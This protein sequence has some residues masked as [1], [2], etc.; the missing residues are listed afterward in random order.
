MAQNKLHI[1]IGFFVASLIGVTLTFSTLHSHHN[2][3]LHNSSEFSDTGQCLTDS[4]ILCPIC[5]HLVQSKEITTD[6]SAVSF[7]VINKIVEH[8][9]NKTNAVFYIPN[10]GRSPPALG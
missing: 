1:V 8:P 9:F 4:N 10:Q 7:T 5:A 2:L 3:E 6:T